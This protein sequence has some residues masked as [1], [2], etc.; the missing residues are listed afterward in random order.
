MLDT[1]GIRE[2]YKFGDDQVG[3][4]IEE[5]KTIGFAVYRSCYS[6]EE[7][8]VFSTRFES[9]YRKYIDLYGYEFLKEIDEHNGIRLPLALDD[10]FLQIAMHPV[11]LKAVSLLLDNKF[12]LN[13]QNG[14]INPPGMTYNQARFH[15]D[16]PYQ[17]FV[18]S[19]PLAVSV[20]YC[21]DDFTKENGATI[22]IPYSHRRE[23]FP[24]GEYV[25][26]HSLSVEAPAGSYIVFDSMLFH[27]GGHNNTTK[28]RRAINHVYAIPLIKQQ[29][30]I[31]N[32]LND[33]SIS[34][35]TPEQKE[36]LGFTYPIYRNVEDYLSSRKKR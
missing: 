24:S 15:R 31:P 3:L 21:V 34:G 11:I 18:S 36:I 14:I 5:V 33:N 22:V 23:E 6:Q 16:L 29:I 10:I 8:Q 35:L 25:T 13:Q 20:L 7:V 4:L 28:P 32:S 1:Y 27:K 12:I 17:H 30:S 26:K 19:K 2:Y 9:C